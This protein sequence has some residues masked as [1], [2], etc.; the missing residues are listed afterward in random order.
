[1]IRNIQV[2]NFAIDRLFVSDRWGLVLVLAGS[3]LSV[4]TL[5]SLEKD[6]SAFPKQ[7]FAVLSFAIDEVG[8]RL[9]VG[10]DVRERSQEP[11]KYRINIFKRVLQQSSKFQYLHTIDLETEKAS[12]R[13]LE[14]VIEHGQRWLCV[15]SSDSTVFVNTEQRSQKSSVHYDGSDF[16]CPGRVSEEAI[17]VKGRQCSIVTPSEERETILFSAACWQVITIKPY[18][19]GMLKNGKIEVR[20]SDGE[21]V[22]VMDSSVED[23]GRWTV[24]V[25]PPE[26]VLFSG[27]EGH[28]RR[29]AIQISHPIRAHINKLLGQSNFSGALSLAQCRLRKEWGDFGDSELINSDNEKAITD[30]QNLVHRCE[31]E[32]ACALLATKPACSISE[33]E[34][35]THLLKSSI[36]TNNVTSGMD[37]H[38]FKLLSMFADT[39]LFP[40]G[41]PEQPITELK[42]IFPSAKAEK[43]SSPARFKP[44]VLGLAVRSIV[45]PAL[46]LVR[47]QKQDEELESSLVTLDSLILRAFV[48]GKPARGTTDGPYEIQ[49]QFFLS[50]NSCPIS[51]SER[52]LLMFPEMWEDHAAL[53]AGKGEFE[54]A[55]DWLK[56]LVTNATSGDAERY[57]AAAVRMLEQ[58]PALALDVAKWMITKAPDVAIDSL[59]RFD[60][61][62]LNESSSKPNGLDLARS[63]FKPFQDADELFTAFLEKFAQQGAQCPSQVL[64]E[65][66][67]IYIK[68]QD[69]DKLFQLLQQGGSMNYESLLS[70][71]DDWPREQALVLDRLDRKREAAFTLATRCSIGDAERY[72]RN[73]INEHV[74][75][76]FDTVLDGL[77]NRPDVSH[78]EALAFYTR[79]FN[80]MQDPIRALGLFSDDVPLASCMGLTKTALAE[81]AAN[82]RDHL[83]IQKLLKHENLVVRQKLAQQK[84]KYVVLNTV[85]PVCKTCGRGFKADSPIVVWNMDVWHFTCFRQSHPNRL[86]T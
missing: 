3:R 78:A 68:A 16:V 47:A 8:D 83:V 12:P 33:V 70:L 5:P 69:S 74:T 85:S 15:S 57:A 56:V 4:L 25:R 59:V 26:T 62:R 76:L 30:A 11:S 24:A 19:I 45:L 58:R 72:A 48:L 46:L 14:H 73:A 13:N 22:Q 43:P 61:F 20:L 64:D 44:G 40:L 50:H 28:K 18:I 55:L 53:L 66:A 17:L 60:C 75:G 65:L 32:Y 84:A 49:K 27:G 41:D 42:S 6:Q 9:L 10:V 82:H 36:L 1:M 31:F 29:M 79:N 81:K 39:D 34:R 80:L 54:R 2:S 23:R 77:I 63:L 21:L 7:E 86:V 37:I 51:E 38:L 67:L 71:L 35:A 52:L